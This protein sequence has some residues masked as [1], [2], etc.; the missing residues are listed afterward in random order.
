MVLHKLPTGEEVRRIGRSI[1]V[2][3]KVRRGVLSTS[4]L[5]GNYREDISAVFNH[6]ENIAPGTSCTLKAPTYKVHLAGIA[7]GLGLDSKKVTGI[8]TAASM[9][10]VAIKE[11]H[12]DD[13]VV[14]AV[15]TGGVEINGGR[16]GDPASYHEKNGK[17]IPHKAGTINILLF[18]NADLD[19]GA[20]TRALVTCTEAKTAA[21]QE[22]M[23]G[24]CYSTGIATGS[25]T[26]GTI[27]ACC[28]ESPVI[29]SYA[30][31]HSKLGELIG[32]C[33]KDGVKEALYLQTGLS[34]SGQHSILRRLKRYGICKEIIYAH[35]KDCCSIGTDEFN[36][37]FDLIDREDRLV[38]VISLCVHLLDQLEWGLLS[39]DE[40][41]SGISDMLGLISSSETKYSFNVKEDLINGI[42]ATLAK[43][44]MEQYHV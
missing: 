41:S 1:V 11:L 36:Q 3:F 8:S 24:S 7:D 23:A 31:K 38:T 22:L 40:V 30:G 16:A 21:L 19:E 14:T 26:D 17:S 29:L 39:F 10:N 12:Y 13:I 4:P 9:E 33:V 43:K 15:V 6:D 2:E 35:M 34:P 20:I 37:F 18:I 44:I 42:A 32:R 28:K 27:I 5:N 25:G